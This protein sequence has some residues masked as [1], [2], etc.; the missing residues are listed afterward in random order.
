MNRRT[1]IV[2]LSVLPLVGILSCNNPIGQKT[3]D[4]IM[5]Q[6]KGK[7]KSKGR[8]TFVVRDKDG[9]IVRKGESQAALTQ[10]KKGK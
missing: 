4:K 1:F 6:N 10:N 2:S 8:V 9:N 3:E 7:A 5:S